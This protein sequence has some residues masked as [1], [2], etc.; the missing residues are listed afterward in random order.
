[1]L[2]IVSVCSALAA[3]LLLGGVGTASAHDESYFPVRLTAVT[4][5]DMGNGHRPLRAGPTQ[6]KNLLLEGRDNHLCACVDHDFSSTFELHECKD[7]DGDGKPDRNSVRKIWDE[8]EVAHTPAGNGR[9]FTFSSDVSE[10]DSWL[11]ARHVHSNLQ[12]MGKGVSDPVTV[13]AKRFKLKLEGILDN[14]PD[15]LIVG[16]LKTLGPPLNPRGSH[17]P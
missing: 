3:L 12:T 7:T 14:Y 16:T 15:T 4:S 6:V 10:S 17:C 9:R 5:Q 1:M 11:G 13:E 2:R 8:D